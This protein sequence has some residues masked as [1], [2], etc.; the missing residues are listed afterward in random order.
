MFWMFLLGFSPILW[1]LIAL[2]IFKLPGHLASLGS[3]VITCLLS[4]IVWKIPILNAITA[5]GEGIALAVWPIIAV[6]IAAIFTYNICVESKAMDTIK[7]MFLQVTNDK[8]LIVL[9][10]GWCFGGF[11]EGM[12]G[13]GTAIA[14]PASMLV[15]LGFNPILASLVCLISNGTPTP[16]GSIGIPTTTVANI[17]ALNVNTLSLFSVLELTPFIILSPFIMV[18]M[19]GKV[20]KKDASIREIFDGISLITLVAALSFYVPELIV[21]KFIG[22]DLT[23]VFGSVIS[24]GLVIFMSKKMAPKSIPDAFT[25]KPEKSSSNNKSYS[26]DFKSLIKAWS[27]FIFIFFL[28]IGTSKVIPPINILVKTVQTSIPI[29]TGPNAKPYVFSWLASPPFWIFLSA[30][31]GGYIQGLN[32]EQMFGVLKK[33]LFELRFAM[34]TMIAILATAKLM[35]YSGM[36]ASIASLLISITGSFYPFISP[37]IGAL[38]TFVTGSGTSSGVLFGKLQSDTALALHYNQSWMVASNS[39]GVSAGKMISPQ[40]IAIATATTGT[41]GQESEI[42]K[43]IIKWAGLYLVVYGILNYIIMMLVH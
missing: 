5:V 11:M 24:M 19:T 37:I 2:I 14:I 33:T 20:L 34:L 16:F 8:R 39:A 15:A 18:F 25:W 26:L 7:E 3:F 43:T 4:I 30:F 1:L 42:F 17:T 6:I 23:V 32:L 22:P 35:G 9:I 10:I 41:A 36:V 21:G 27:P 12:A 29:Y 40:S 13:F 31:V 38:G 28:L